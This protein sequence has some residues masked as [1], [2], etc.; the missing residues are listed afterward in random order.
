MGWQEND[1]FSLFILLSFICYLL[2]KEPGRMDK[3]GYC[4]SFGSIANRD[5]L[6]IFFRIL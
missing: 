1:W 6:L 2:L 5:W 4:I 3:M